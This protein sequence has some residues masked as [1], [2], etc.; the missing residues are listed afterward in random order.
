M[1]GQALIWSVIVVFG[2]ADA[3][4]L[5]AQGMT[6][7]GWSF[8]FLIVVIL[9]GVALVYRRRSPPIACG[10]AAGAQI[11]AFSHVGALL[12]Y[13]AM[14]ASPFP[15]ADALLSD[16]DASLGF[17]WLRWFAVVNAHP[18]LHVALGLAYASIPVQV[19]GLIGW[20][21]FH[22]TRRVHELLLAAM[23][24]IALITPVMVVLPAIGAWSGHAV[25]MA[26]PWRGDILAL[27]SHT[28]L[29]VGET[30]GIIS[31]PSFHTVLAVLFANMARGGRWFP[32]VLVVNLLM[33]ASVA[34][35]GAHYGVDILSGLAVAVVALGAARLLLARCASDGAPVPESRSDSGGPIAMAAHPIRGGS[36]ARRSGGKPSD[37]RLTS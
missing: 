19:F 30:K 34:T 37:E 31:F 18:A 23:L 12:T 13:G 29:A 24:S 26:E 33:I 21:A 22:D 1:N 27:R 14:A 28:L 2:V 35:E 9:C 11:V 10:F 5:P 6:V 4:L 25:G 7:T 17:D 16:A 15:L 20:F 32:P 8:P 36:G 3:V